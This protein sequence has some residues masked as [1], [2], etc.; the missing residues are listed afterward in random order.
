M[1]ANLL[2]NTTDLL[3]T[4]NV[5][6][7]TNST[8]PIPYGSINS[9]DNAEI[10]TGAVYYKPEENYLFFYLL[11]AI[12]IC[13]GVITVGIWVVVATRTAIVRRYGPEVCTCCGVQWCRPSQMSDFTIAPPSEFTNDKKEETRIE[14]FTFEE[15]TPGRAKSSVF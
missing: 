8:T 4:S 11:L 2:E 7:N 5:W 3:L 1:T 15:G 13:I 14:H 10:K 9:T 12:P 6:S